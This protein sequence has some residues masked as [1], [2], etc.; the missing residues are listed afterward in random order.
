[1]KRWL[2]VCRN[3]LSMP[4]AVIGFWAWGWSAF[5]WAG[6]PD[7]RIGSP[8]SVLYGSAFG[9]AALVCGLLFVLLNERKRWALLSI[10]II[11]DAIL[12]LMALA[13]TFA[14][15]RAESGAPLLPQ[16]WAAIGFWVASLAAGYGLFRLARKPL[17]I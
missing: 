8:E 7:G 4:F 12:L 6:G 2:T 1:M 17:W 13:L 11:Y 15:F 3:V 16:L 10:G 9:L 5:C 14:A